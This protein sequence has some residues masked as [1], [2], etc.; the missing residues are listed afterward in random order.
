MASITSSPSNSQNSATKPQDAATGNGLPDALEK[1]TPSVDPFEDMNSGEY[2]KRF[3]K[4]EADYTR[5]LMAK[6]FSDKDIYGGLSVFDFIKITCHL[7]TTYLMKARQSM[8]RLLRRAGGIVLN[9][10]QTLSSS[11]KRRAS[12]LQLLLQTPRLPSQTGSTQWMMGEVQ[13]RSTLFTRLKPKL[14]PAE[15]TVYLLVELSLRG[16]ATFSILLMVSIH[17]LR[18]V[19]HYGIEPTYGVG[20]FR[21]L[22]L[23]VVLKS[24][25]ISSFYMKPF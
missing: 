22:S 5:R 20:M 25:I 13:V 7:Q 6:Y 15:V 11:S 9:H 1:K 3:S 23:M 17:G 2:I 12:A 24:S 4:Y 8:A 21:K 14:V 10:M 16:T 18:R 19:L